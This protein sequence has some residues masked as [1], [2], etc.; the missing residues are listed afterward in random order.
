MKNHL[1]LACLVVL[2]GIF[3]NS[4]LIS[5]AANPP[6]I[7]AVLPSSAVVGEE[8]AI[9]FEGDGMAGGDTAKWVV[10]SDC[11]KDVADSGK[12]DASG[13]ATFKFAM[14]GFYSLCWLSPSGSPQLVPGVSLTA[15]KGAIYDIVVD[16]HDPRV[17]AEIPS[18]IQ[19]NSVG[20]TVGD[21]AKW[22]VGSSCAV[23]SQVIDPDLVVG[24]TAP[25]G[26]GD[27]NTFTFNFHSGVTYKLCYKWKGAPPGALRRKDRPA[28][29]AA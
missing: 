21:T 22:I 7:T 10:G 15:A 28:A 23:D 6:T 1:S 8:T 25:V 16:Y 13:K 26:V 4:L 27:N 11:H 20:G 3:D 24:D 14:S 17:Y 29:K 9:I 2:G 5:H 19:F 18:P 12:I